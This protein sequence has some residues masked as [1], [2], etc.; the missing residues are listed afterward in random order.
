MVIFGA[1]GDLT[2]KKLMPALYELSR[3][4]LLPPG[5]S[6]IGCAITPY[7]DDQ[8]RDHI[9]DAIRQN[10]HVASEDSEAFLESFHKGV[11]YVTA[12]FSDPKAYEE[13]GR[14]LDEIDRTRGTS[15]N[16]LFYLAT[17]PSFFPV[18]VNKL[19]ES[20]LSKAKSGHSW[21][22]IVIEKP[23]GRDLERAR[24][25][26]RTVTCVFEEEQIY[27]IDHYLGKETVQNLL[28]FRFAN[29]IFEPVW[30]RRYIDN[31]QI[32]VAEDIGVENRGA[33]YEEAGLVR[34]MIQNHVMSL[35]SLVAME[36]PARFAGTSVRDEKV[37][38]MRAIRP[39]ALDRLDE[40]AVRSQYT[41]GWVEGHEVPAYRAEPHVDPHSTTETHA[42]FKLLIDN[43]RWA[44]VP[45]YI[46][47]GKRMAK[48]ASA[49]TVVF[50]EV[51]F[52]PFE[53]ISQDHI[54]PN[55]LSLRIQPNEGIN[56][57]FSAKLPGTSLLIRPVNMDFGYGQAFGTRQPSAYET[58][59]LDC[60]LGDS[61]LFNRA[62][63]V[64]TSWELLDPVLQRWKELGEKGLAF[65]EAGSWGPPE[66]DRLIQQDGRRW[67]RL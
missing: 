5:F 29:G 41:E 55:L 26:N 6:V 46:R 9:R 7:S 60:M 11:F 28:V 44:G 38:V 3:D 48:R 63:S 19:G 34:D 8:F 58:L 45:F 1:S 62:D 61:T 67:E 25:L 37:K 22:R 24:E 16:R 23:F 14:R 32:R 2:E 33:Y 17:Q 53:G 12:D 64:E 51:P 20:G 49:I 54:E 59:L 15:G 36:P 31:V 40:F 43:W 4:R 57:R 39:I 47:S 50:R 42:A 52:S 27:R 21:T 30:N 13:L 56:L 35:L 65:Y 10:A 66:I 18:I